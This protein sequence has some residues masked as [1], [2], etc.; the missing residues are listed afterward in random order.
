MQQTCVFNCFVFCFLL[1]I[2]MADSSPDA[3]SNE[4]NNIKLDDRADDGKSNDDVAIDDENPDEADE[5][6]PVQADDQDKNEPMDDGNEN[7]LQGDVQDT[8]EQMEGVDAQDDVPDANAPIIGEEKA[9]E[10]QGDA[11][12]EDDDESI[13]TGVQDDTVKL[14]EEADDKTNEDQNKFNGPDTNEKV[15]STLERKAFNLSPAEIEKFKLWPN[16]TVSY[17]IDEFSYD[18]VLRD[19]I[20]GYLDYAGLNTMVHFHELSEPPTDEAER[21]VLFVNRRGALDCKDYSTN[22]FTNK[23]VQ[24]VTVG[25]N[26]LKHGG[27]MAGIVLALLGVPPQ[28]NSPDRDKFIT[29]ATEHILPEKVGL[30]N[31]LRNDEWLFHDLEYDYSS[32][33]HYP[34]HKYTADGS[35]TI[36]AKPGNLRSGKPHEDFE[37]IL[38]TEEVKDYSHG[39]LIKTYLLYGNILRKK[40]LKGM[41]LT[42][43]KGL[44]RP[45]PGFG[46]TRMTAPKEL[47]EMPKPKQYVDAAKKLFGEDF[48]MFG[49]E[50]LSSL[51]S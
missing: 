18:K 50:T 23:G 31:V 32:A 7:N 47:P 33:G 27:P 26:C 14:G 20:R 38:N 6:D 10:E 12:V 37:N 4:G 36:S 41:K 25:Y 35:S 44:F 48:L 40:Q 1:V 51:E 28:H 9:N 24:K 30:F 15:I 3:I 22:S 13:K 2:Y 42:D 16:A 43:C 11:P 5:N 46:N 29:V 45:G 21:W 19:K 39:D 49:G 17:F 8:T 34:P